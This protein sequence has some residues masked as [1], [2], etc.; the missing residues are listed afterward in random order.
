M[1]DPNKNEAMNIYSNCQV[2][3]QVLLLKNSNW[4]VTDRGKKIFTNPTTYRRVI[5]KIYKD[6]KKLTSKIP[7]N[8]IQKKKKMGIEL[9]KISQ[10]RNLGCLRNT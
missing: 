9:N 7:N 2:Y 3:W 10:P 4:Q 8:P 6:L 5:S 1:Q